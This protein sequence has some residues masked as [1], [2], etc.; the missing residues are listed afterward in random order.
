[1]WQIEEGQLVGRGQSKSGLVAGYAHAVGGE[2]GFLFSQGLELDREK[3]SL[4]RPCTKSK[5]V[6]WQKLTK[7]GL[8]RLHCA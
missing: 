3:E 6:T 4:P 7:C 1:M 2:L 8:P 5:K